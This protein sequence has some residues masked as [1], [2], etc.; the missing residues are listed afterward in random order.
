MSPSPSTS[1]ANTHRAPSAVLEMVCEVKPWLPLFSYQA[2]LSSSEDAERTSMSP[3]PSTSA[4]NTDRAETAVLE[5]T[6]CAPNTP[7]ARA[8]CTMVIW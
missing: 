8:G 4:A 1:A 7:P 2:I 5:I 6:V 3:S